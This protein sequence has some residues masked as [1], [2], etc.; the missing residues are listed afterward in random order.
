MQKCCV[1]FATLD[2][3]S[4][5]DIKKYLWTYVNFNEGCRVVCSFAKTNTPPQMMPIVPEP[6][7][8]TLSGC[9]YLIF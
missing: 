4:Y 8:S 5:D 9:F 2:H 7:Q 3:L 1:F 6:K